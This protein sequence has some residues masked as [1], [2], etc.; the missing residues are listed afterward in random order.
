MVVLLKESDHT[1]DTT[2][3][4]SVF[5]HQEL[6]LESLCFLLEILSWLPFLVVDLGGPYL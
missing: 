3:F 5:Y 2:S 6:R 4:L 1:Y